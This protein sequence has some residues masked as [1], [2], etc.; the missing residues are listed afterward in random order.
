MES[1]F[2][3]HICN[4]TENMHLNYTRMS[5]KVR[6]EHQILFHGSLVNDNFVYSSAIGLFFLT[7]AVCQV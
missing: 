4:Y 7:S 6:K 2:K 5:S 3:L 1:S